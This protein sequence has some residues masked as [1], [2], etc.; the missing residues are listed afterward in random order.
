[1]V[2]VQI[3]TSDGRTLIL[4]RYT[5][6]QADLRLLRERLKLKLPAQPPPRII[7]A[8]DQTEPVT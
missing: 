2:D 6:P 4:R 8:S 1:M 7:V 5:P 3:P